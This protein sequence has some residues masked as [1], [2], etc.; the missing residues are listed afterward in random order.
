MDSSNFNELMRIQR[1]VASQ[2]AEES[3]Q[4]TKIQVMTMINE[5]SAGKDRIP[6]E[7][8]IIEAGIEGISE[9]TVLKLVDQL[10]RDGI[11]RIPEEGFIQQT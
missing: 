7:S 9:D 6:I 11:I 4:D 3:D 10:K 2:I 5:L 1:M 8:L